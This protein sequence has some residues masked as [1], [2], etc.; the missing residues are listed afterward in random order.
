[1]GKCYSDA[2]ERALGYLYY[3]ETERKGQEA[4]ELLKQ[5]SEAGD[6]D[7]TCVLAR[8]MCGSQYV[9]EGH[10][11]PDNGKEAARLLHRSVEQGSALGVLVSLR[12]GE[13]P[14]FRERKMP[15]SSIQEAFDI[16][17]EK[18]KQGDA[19]SQYT[20]GNSYFW[21]DF[22]RIQGKGQ[23]SFS[24]HEEFKAY[25][26]ENIEQCEDWFRKAFRG[27]MYL[28]GNNLRHYYTNGDE[29]IILPQPEKA[30]P[31]ARMGAEYGYPYYEKEYGS[32]LLKQKRAD[33]G[34]M[35]LKKAADH[36]EVSANYYIGQAYYLG[37]GVE[38][39][40]TLAIEYLQKALN[41][42]D[43]GMGSHNLLGEIYYQGFGVE[44]DY[45]KAFGLLSWA[46]ERGST[47]GVNYLGRCCFYGR[48]TQQD[49]VRARQ[50]LEQIDGTPKAEELYMLGY[51]YGNG[52]GVEADIPKA[53]AYLQKAGNFGP[54]V[55]ELRNYKK[56]FFTGKWVRR[57]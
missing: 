29:D 36:G 15:F 6:G 25:L 10:G 26:K 37:K 27:G 41:A 47:W 8:C 57:K 33:E 52:L 14:E 51:I 22:L 13:L 44:P 17:L 56:T 12:S 45:A 28:A 46:Y 3:H 30:E 19:F 54:A 20:I 38:E 21:W 18:A 5:A 1:M 11:F 7:A 34:M 49:Y 4:L 42:S 39:N 40:N 43:G 31:I 9:W 55:E 53:V 50:M 24:S 48:G 35:W 23:N 16:V 2:V 32:E